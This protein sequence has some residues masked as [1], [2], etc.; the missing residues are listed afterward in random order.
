MTITQSECMSKPNSLTLFETRHWYW[1]LTFIWKYAKWKL[2]TCKE[3][4]YINA[5]TTNL[6]IIPQERAHW[7][8]NLIKRIQYLINFN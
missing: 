2:E 4:V 1:T 3:N 7:E 5:T 6:P 8:E